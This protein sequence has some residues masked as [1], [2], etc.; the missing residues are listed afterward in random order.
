MA[1]YGPFMVSDSPRFIMATIITTNRIVP[2]CFCNAS[3]INL[4][5]PLYLNTVWHKRII[6]IYTF[7]QTSRKN[8]NW[9]HFHSHRSIALIVGLNRNFYYLHL[10]LHK[11]AVRHVSYSCTLSGRI[12]KNYIVK[13]TTQI[14]T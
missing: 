7:S 12:G 1:L 5:L 2:I 10:S 13:N 11:F 9:L 14:N 3:V 8:R 4:D 6:H